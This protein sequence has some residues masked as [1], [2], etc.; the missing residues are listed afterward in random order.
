MN[1]CL[2]GCRYREPCDRSELM[3]LPEVATECVCFLRAEWATRKP[4]VGSAFLIALRL[5]TKPVDSVFTYAVTARHCIEDDDT[6][7][8]A[9]DV[10][11]SLNLRG[12]GIGEL[13]TETVLWDR[14]PTADV[15][16]LPIGYLDHDRFRFQIWDM[17]ST[18]EAVFVEERKIGPG[19]DVYFSG[20]L[21]HHPGKSQIMPIARIGNIAGMPRDPIQLTTGE[22]T[23]ALVEARSIGGLS[24]SPVFLHLPFWRDQP[25]G[26]ASLVV[27]PGG[28]V[29]DSGG[30]S[31][32]FGVMHGFYPVGPND[33][34]GVSGGDT[35]L[36]TGIAVVVFVDRVVELLNLPDRV[37]ERDNM[38]QQVED[39]VKLAGVLRTPTSMEPL[40]F[41]TADELLRAQPRPEDGGSA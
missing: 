35:N 30:E 25:E 16:I 3:R 23:V 41:G 27:R 18:A 6:G 28:A 9:E 39:A 36:N 1:G 11:L 40:A 32:L 19:D 21:V 5:G 31:R 7:D 29:A 33:P 10:T 4:T 8:L 14:H 34:D 20:L 37:S 2:S 13:A 17:N 26:A 12:G 38:R 24:G 15:A 22:D